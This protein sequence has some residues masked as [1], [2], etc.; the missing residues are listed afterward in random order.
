MICAEMSGNGV[1]IGSQN[2]SHPI[3]IIRQDP[4]PGKSVASAEALFLPIFFIV[5]LTVTIAN[6]NSK[7]MS[8]V[9]D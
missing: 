8:T 2:T 9:S 7:K 5:S 1:T 3:K 4:Q 6:L